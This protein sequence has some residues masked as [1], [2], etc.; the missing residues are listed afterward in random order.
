MRDTGA[1]L[2]KQMRW[3]ISDERQASTRTIHMIHP[4]S[5]NTSTNRQMTHTKPSVIVGTPDD[6][7]ICVCD[8]HIIG[9]EVNS[10]RRCFLCVKQLGFC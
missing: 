7:I 9:W 4:N 8:T 2:P 6:H 10:K 5:N 3:S 1:A